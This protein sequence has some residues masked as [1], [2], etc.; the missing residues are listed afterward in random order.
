[1]LKTQ[2]GQAS[3]LDLIHLCQSIRVA[4]LLVESTLWDRAQKPVPWGDCPHCGH[5]LQSKGWQPRQ[6][7]TGVGKIH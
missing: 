6:L 3:Y 2:S 5:R 7:E 1:M 4:R